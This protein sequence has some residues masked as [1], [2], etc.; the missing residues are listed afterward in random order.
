MIPTTKI[1][2]LDNE[3][4][5]DIILDEVAFSYGVLTMVDEKSGKV[6]T[7]VCGYDG[8]KGEN[9]SQQEYEDRIYT[10]AHSAVMDAVARAEE[11]EYNDFEGLDLDANDGVAWYDEVREDAIRIVCG[12]FKDGQKEVQDDV[13]ER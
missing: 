7:E 8:R 10:D 13:A 3:S 1:A 6:F 9:E 4:L 12:W 2:N 5:L 11:D